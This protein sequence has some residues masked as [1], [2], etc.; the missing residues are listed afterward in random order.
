VLLALALLVGGIARIGHQ[1]GPYDASLNRSFATQGA[2]LVDQ[3]DLTAS[4]LRHL[5]AATAGLSR[6]TLQADLDGLATQ[7]G[8]QATRAATLAA[9]GGVQGQF[10]LVFAQRA[11]GVTDLRAAFDGLLDMQ[12]L[13]V[14][15][16]PALVTRVRGTTTSLSSTQASNRITAAGT[17]LARA[18]RTYAALRRTLAHVAGHARL[19]ASRWISN[20]SVWQIGAVTAT[21]NQIAAALPVSHQLVLSVVQV[22]PPALPS[23][24]GV[25]TPAASDLSP[26]RAVVLNVVLTNAGTADEPRAEVQFSLALQ[27]T[28]TTATATR[29][30]ALAASRSTS[31]APVS[32]KVKPGNSYQLTVAIQLP[33]GEAATAQTSTSELLR[34]APSS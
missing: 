30:T 27:P 11:Q 8:D 24:S 34:I 23:P 3:S 25:T 4:S 1:S 9:G 28:G 32:F 10:A 2:V 19:P 17:L 22:T 15:G 33:A 14:A 21:V 7:A 12:P 5:M 31:L 18:D 26:T 20:P 29:R 6:L 13:P 16:A